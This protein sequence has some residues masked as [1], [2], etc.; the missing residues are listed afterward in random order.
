MSFYTSTGGN[1]LLSAL[2]AS[3]LLAACASPN[4]DAAFADLN[5][6]VAG[7][8]PDAAVWRTGG[9]EDAAVDA[10]VDA[11]MAEPLTAQSAAQVALLSNRG[12]QARYASLGI[13]QADVVQAGLLENPVFEI[14]VRPS[15]EEGTNIEL[16]LMQN[17][18]DLLMRPARIKLAA[19]EY[20]VTKLDLAAHL[21]AFVGDV[22]NAYYAHRGALGTLDV[23]KEVAGTARDG[24]SLARAFHT[25]G[26]IS[27][28][29]LA[30]H[31]ADAGDAHVELLE[32]E[33]EVGDSRIELAEL[34]GVSHNAKW[35]VSSRPPS[36]PDTQVKLTGLEQQALKNRFDLTAHRAEVRAALAELGMEEDFRLVEDADLGVSAEKEPDGAWLIGPVF[37]IPLPLF[38][39]GQTR[40]AS[41]TMALR[42]AQDELA[43]EESHVRLQVKRAADSM[44]LARQRAAHLLGTVLP[45]KER[46]VRLTLAEYNYMLES[47]FHLLETQQEQNESY[48]M[49]VEA[50]TDY[51]MARADLQAAIGGGP[52]KTQ[53]A[54]SSQGD[55]S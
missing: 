31:Q 4:P 7:R 21:V 44:V 49:Y 8:I 38:D 9:P 24:A 40:L 26:N 30:T 52:L 51:W 29:D 28:L 16:G 41:A 50:L 54:A 22:Q 35:T 39:Q 19:A 1:P 12:L 37:E 18:V 3:V 17:F 45:L 20:D 46:I 48:R 6:T 55:A 23:A 13:A 47:P 42:R 53:P 25:A 14:M 10:R 43:A 33:E 2:I 36:L 34:L 15:T 32:S 11:L 27:D 5:K